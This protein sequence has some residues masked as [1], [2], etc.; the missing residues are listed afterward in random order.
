MET[1]S[2][3][4]FTQYYNPKKKENITMHTIKIEKSKL[5]TNL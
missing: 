1:R 3:N 2:T 5:L 4:Q